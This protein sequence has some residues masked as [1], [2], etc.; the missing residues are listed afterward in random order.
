[1]K[2]FNIEDEVSFS[3]NV[4]FE[5]LPKTTVAWI[6]NRAR[7]AI[8]EHPE[9]HSGEEMPGYNLAKNLKYVFAKTDHLEPFTSNEEEIHDVAAERVEG[10][11]PG[12]NESKDLRTDGEIGK[13]PEKPQVFVSEALAQFK[14]GVHAHNHELI[15]ILIEAASAYEKGNSFRLDIG[16]PIEISEEV[17]EEDGT[18]N[19]KGEK[20]GE[21]P[22]LTKT[23]SEIVSDHE[24]SAGEIQ[25]EQKIKYT[26]EQIEDIK[27]L[28]QLGI[29]KKLITIGKGSVVVNGEGDEGI[30]AFYNGQ[31]LCTMIDK[32]DIDSIAVYF[33]NVPAE[34]TAYTLDI[35]KA[36]TSEDV[37][38]EIDES[39]TKSDLSETKSDENVKENTDNVSEDSPITYKKKEDEGKEEAGEPDSKQEE[40]EK[41]EV[42]VAISKDEY[43][44]KLI[45][46]NR[47]GGRMAQTIMEIYPSPADLVAGHKAKEFKFNAT[48]NKSL[49]DACKNGY[50]D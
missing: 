24:K 42:P 9:G 20:I 12:E 25:A 29:D 7:Q 32:D 17:H 6:D 8:I 34:L 18:Y 43:R 10:A 47:I 38:S 15:N 30:A 1:M 16:N 13:V 14:E 50:F 27:K 46:L 33:Y 26:K 11:G 45:K 2:E 36:E 22:K 41:D 31:P 40:T 49:K 44:E 4:D 21:I 5:A 3:G 23:T 48:V 19:A 35:S 39:E 28:V 37:G